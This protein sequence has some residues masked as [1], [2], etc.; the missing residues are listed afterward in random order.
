MVDQWKDLARFRKDGQRVLRWIQRESV[1]MSRDP[2]AREKAVRY[3]LPVFQALEDV[4]RPLPLVAVY[5]YRQADQPPSLRTDSGA[6][7]SSVDG[8]QWTDVT[9][10][11]SELYAIDLSVE[12]V[13]MGPDYLQFLFLHE[14]THIFSGGGHSPEFHRQLDALIA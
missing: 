12:A 7:M 3:L 6:P 8:I 13:D 11:R 5:A 2:S 1:V 14:L 4:I 9:P 10:D